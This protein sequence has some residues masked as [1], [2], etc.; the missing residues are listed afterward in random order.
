M[1]KEL[2]QQLIRQIAEQMDKPEER[3]GKK[4]KN[5]IIFQQKSHILEY[6]QLF[7]SL[8]EKINKTYAYYFRCVDEITQIIENVS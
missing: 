3:Q 2:S 8:R 6:G 1:L 4:L 7:M 5:Q